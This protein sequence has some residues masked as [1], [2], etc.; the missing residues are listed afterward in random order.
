M[1]KNSSSDMAFDD[2]TARDPEELSDHEALRKENEVLFDYLHALLTPPPVL[3]IESGK[4]SFVY[5]EP[6]RESSFGATAPATEFFKSLESTWAKGDSPDLR[7]ENDILKLK[8]AHLIARLNDTEC[9]LDSVHAENKRLN[10]AV[11]RLQ[12][13]LKISRMIAKNQGDISKIKESSVTL[14]TP[15]EPA[16]P[17]GLAVN[18]SEPQLDPVA[19]EIPG[20]EVLNLEDVIEEVMEAQPVQLDNPEPDDRLSRLAAAVQPLVSLETTEMVAVTMEPAVKAEAPRHPLKAVPLESAMVAVNS[21]PVEAPV[22]A[23]ETTPLEGAAGAENAERRASRGAPAAQAAPPVPVLDQVR[24]QPDR[25]PAP[26]RP[27]A[28]FVKPAPRGLSASKV[29]KR[30][31]LKRPWPAAGLEPVAESAPEAPV[32]QPAPAAPERPPVEAPLPAEPAA[33]PEAEAA[34]G[35]EMLQDEVD[36]TGVEPAPVPKALVKRQMLHYQQNQEQADRGGKRGPDG[37]GPRP[38][39]TVKTEPPD[40]Q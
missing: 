30:H 17:A 22:A 27:S 28:V 39:Q 25:Q 29:I 10:A 20:D 21:A 38:D 7:H 14:P 26:P 33:L 4:V 24:Q 31:D 40:L 19:R 13:Q 9:D 15:D 1:S 34:A 5:N 18:E 37:V 8:V 36:V 35:K 23:V 3:N 16:P 32:L 11:D 2:D 12:T 6:V